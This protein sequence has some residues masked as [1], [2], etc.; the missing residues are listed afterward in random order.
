M[1]ISISDYMNEGRGVVV[2]I[3]LSRKPVMLFSLLPVTAD[4]GC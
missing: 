1:A 4:K 3:P 2:T